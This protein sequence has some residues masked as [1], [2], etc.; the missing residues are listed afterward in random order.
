MEET[1]DELVQ[2]LNR[3]LLER[4]G[5]VIVPAFAVGRTQEMLFVLAE[6]VR[7]GRVE[8]L[9]VVVDSPM[10]SAVTELTLRHEAL[11]D[12]ETRDLYR[13]Y[14]AHTDR[15]R[16]RLVEDVEE[17]MALN[18]QREGLVIISA[19]GMCEAG[20]VRHHLRH[21]IDRPEC[22]IVIVG[23]QA[24]GT[25]GRRLV[26]GA[27]QV[28]LFGVRLP[29]R[30]SIHTIGGLSA[31]ADQAALLEWMRYLQEPPRQ[32]FVVHGEAEA[33]S[34]LARMV[35]M[36]LDWPAPVVPLARRPYRLR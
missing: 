30:A 6:I 10:A 19:S 18:E 4:R 3:T 21:N 16:L 27:R 1:R 34:E 7:S 13:W 15:F 31:H 5:N 8:R 33:A 26:D 32:T 22:A 35:E 29:V 14:S 2:V 20:R 28:S 11:W 23:F 25:L 9:E 36:R 17:S 24:G 12:D